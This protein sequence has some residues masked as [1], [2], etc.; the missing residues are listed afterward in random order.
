MGVGM[1]WFV[2]AAEADRAVSLIEARGF[3]A[4]RI[5]EVVSGSGVTV[6]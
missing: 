5:G 2:P 4:R 1:V 6:K 3:T